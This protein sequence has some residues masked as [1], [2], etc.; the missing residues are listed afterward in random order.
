MCALYHGCTTASAV[1]SHVVASVVCICV[2][3]ASAA[4]FFVMSVPLPAWWAHGFPLLMCLLCHECTSISIVGS[5]VPAVNV[6]SMSWMYH[7]Q[8]SGLICCCQCSVLLCC[9][10]LCGAAICSVL[11]CHECT[12][13]S[14][15]GLWVPAVNVSSMSWVYHY[16]SSGLMLMCLLCHECTTASAVGSYVAA[17]VVCFYVVCV[18]VGLPA[19]ACFYVMPA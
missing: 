11:L 16:Q 5:C 13:A 12:T 7:C 15:V 3:A 10:C 2:G 17:S 14:V 1:G 19:A 18:C 6:S 4:C 9:V 8:R